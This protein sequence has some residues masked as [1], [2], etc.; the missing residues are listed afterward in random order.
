MTRT[1][2]NFQYFFNYIPTSITRSYSVKEEYISQRRRIWDFKDG[3]NQSSIIEATSK[4]LEKVKKD[5][6]DHEIVFITIPAST[7]EKN[8]IRFKNFSEQVSVKAGVTN[9]F[10]ILKNIADREAAHISGTPT[11]QGNLECTG[12][13][14]EGKVIVIFDDL[15]TSGSS[16][17]NACTLLSIKSPAKFTGLFLGKTIEYKDI[18]DFLL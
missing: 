15:I 11:I 7:E 17:N 2:H 5:N 12:G 10:G 6:P 14:L 4:Q 16:F 13:S 9:G 3:R 18:D 1:V 8:N